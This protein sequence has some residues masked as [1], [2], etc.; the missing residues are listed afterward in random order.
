MPP[1]APSPATI[2]N[3]LQGFQASGVLNAAIQLGVFGALARGP[4]AASQVAAAVRCPER[5]A[6]I[7]CDA[8]ASMGLLHKEHRRYRLSLDAAHFLVPGRPSYAGGAARIVC[9]PALWEAFG[10]FAQAVRHGG[11]VLPFHAE[12]PGQKFW[13]TFADN[14]DAFAA[15]AAAYAQ[16]LL[17]RFVD[18]RS[19]ARILD[20]ACGS[21]L[22][23]LTLAA[24]SPGARVTLMDGTHVMPSVKKRTR[25][26]GLSKRVTCLPGDMFRTGLGGPYHA[27][28]A[29][30]VLHHFSPDTCESLL[31]RFAAALVPGGRLL[32]HEFVSAEDGVSNPHAAM[33]AAVM[34]AWTR[35][36]RTYSFSEYSRM[37][38][39]T[40][41]AAPV[42][43]APPHL[44]SQFLVGERKAARRP[45]KK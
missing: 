27:I 29:S 38:T 1:T 12:T 13:E 19:P 26:L 24:H 8:L 44:T 6:S 25:E 11:T 23:G 32:V 17:Q 3:L 16:S 42:L 39:K 7:L 15:P 21:G 20:V 5:S 22:Y 4:R 30:H 34:L 14:S 33:F 2:F 35:E 18:E 45:A 9:D 10:R 41:F 36:G 40:G 28:I 43:H 31:R 37:F